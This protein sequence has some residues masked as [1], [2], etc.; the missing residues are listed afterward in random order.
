[1]GCVRLARHLALGWGLPRDVD[2]ARKLAARACESRAEGWSNEDGQ[3]YVVVG[4][5]C[6]MSSQLT[7]DPQRVRPLLER[8]CEVGYVGFKRV[9]YNVWMPGYPVYEGACGSPRLGQPA[10]ARRRR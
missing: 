1:M 4:E 9:I 10:R 2:R 8:V 7:E 5:G 3:Y 6:L